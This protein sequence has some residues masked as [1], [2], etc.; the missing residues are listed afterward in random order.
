MALIALIALIA[1]TFFAHFLVSRTPNSH[2]PP[3]LYPVSLV[4]LY[5][6]SKIQVPGTTAPARKSLLVIHLRY[7]TR[8]AWYMYTGTDR[9]YTS[10]STIR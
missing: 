1:L 9:W 4:T 2:P 7:R 5:A 8:V 6:V 3:H 10:L